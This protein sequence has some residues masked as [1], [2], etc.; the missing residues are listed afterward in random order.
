M[1]EFEIDFKRVSHD[2]L[3]ESVRSSFE[4][5]SRVYAA[6]S[7]HLWEEHCT[8]C[9]YPSC[10]TTCD[11]YEP[12]KDGNCRRFMGGLST[13]EDIANDQ[14]YV[15]EITFKRWGLLMALGRLDLIDADKARS[16]ERRLLSL[17]R[18]AGRIPD[19]RI[20]ILGRRGLSANL[21][22]RLKKAAVRQMVRRDRQEQQPDYFLLELYNPGDVPLDLTLQISP[23]TVSPNTLPFQHRLVLKHG[24]H[25]VEIPFVQIQPFLDPAQEHYVTL[26]PNFDPDGPALPRVFIGSLCFVREVEPATPTKSA[27]AKTVKVVAW[28]LDNTVWDGILIE[29]GANGLRLKPGIR[30]VM[31]TLDRRGIVNSVVSKNTYEDA[32]D[33]L[34]R[35]GLD[36]LIVFPK[37]SWGPKSEAVR[38]LIADFN[39]GADT[40]VFLDDDRFER[41]EVKAGNPNVRVLDSAEYLALPDLP[42]F[43]PEVSRESADRRQSYQKQ[44]I[45]RDA[46]ASFSGDYRNFL[47]SCELNMSIMRGSDDNLER[48]QELVQRTNQMNFSGSRYDRQRVAEL[49]HDQTY[50]SFCVHCKDRFGD[51]GNVGFALV[52]RQIEEN[53][54]FTPQLVDLMFSCRVQSKRTEHAFLIWLLHHYREQGATSLGVRYMQTPKNAP[55]GKV[56]DDLGFHDTAASEPRLLTYALND[57]LPWDG[58]WRIEHEGR[59]WRRPQRS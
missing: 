36:D 13:L 53:T 31:E 2:R 5:S 4:D 25:R 14:G 30:Q 28:D 35:F 54:A 42:E 38:S 12:R 19:G 40:V 3:P 55:A 16:V 29:A 56:F 8:E 50:D 32:M 49:I 6:R 15:V 33:Q 9:A 39:V 27:A 11:L 18:L 48:I 45:R 24:F 43:C 59:L 37:I 7:I 21:A 58:L 41:E 47:K 23:K 17:S 44:K 34:K 26:T 22:R 20:E 52:K 51:Y 10:Y 57:E 1:F 46:Q